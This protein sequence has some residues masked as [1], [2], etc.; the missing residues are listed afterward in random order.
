MFIFP[1]V[2]DHTIRFIKVS[3][4][5]DISGEY[6]LGNR[7]MHLVPMIFSA[8]ASY[9]STVVLLGFPAEMFAFGIQ[10]W[11][12]VFATAAGALLAVTVFVPVFYPLKLTSVHE[13][14]HDDV[15]KWEHFPRY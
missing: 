7:R 5:F 4:Y 9:L 8:T 10:H 6:F 12:G 11:L 3:L 15:I 14:S 2:K 13:V 1:V